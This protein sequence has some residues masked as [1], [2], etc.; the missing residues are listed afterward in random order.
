MATPVTIKIAE[1]KL[2]AE[3]NDSLSANTFKSL[4]P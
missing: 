2:L 4:L 1:L 3:L